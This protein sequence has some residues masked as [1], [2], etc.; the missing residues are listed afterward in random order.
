MAVVVGCPSAGSRKGGGGG[1]TKLPL[2]AVSVLLLLTVREWAASLPP[3]AA[4]AL[5]SLAG[6]AN[7]TNG[8]EVYGQPMD[9]PLVIMSTVICMGGC[10][11]PM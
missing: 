5:L 3:V 6:A 10:C 9:S 2:V 11:G 7:A 8:I 4:A 1:P